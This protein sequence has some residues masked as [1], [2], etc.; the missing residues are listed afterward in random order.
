MFAENDISALLLNG[1]KL[2]GIDRKLN[3]RVF[4]S[5]N[6]YMYSR[7]T[8]FDALLIDRV[9]YYKFTLIP[10]FL[11]TRNYLDASSLTHV[12]FMQK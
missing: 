4:Q 6:I 1:L 9:V 2:F 3:E 8:G 5:F 10:R 12:V 11:C 7:L